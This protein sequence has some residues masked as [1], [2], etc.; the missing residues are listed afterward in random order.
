MAGGVCAVDPNSISTMEIKPKFVLDFVKGLVN[1]C[2]GTL[3][4]EIIN[5]IFLLEI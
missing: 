1:P 2:P 5:R 4:K 3:V